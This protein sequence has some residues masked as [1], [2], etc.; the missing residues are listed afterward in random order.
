MAGAWTRSATATRLA[1]APGHWPI[2]TFTVNL[3]GALILGALLE[4]LSRQTTDRP[5]MSR[6]RLLAGTGFCG[7]LT[8]YSTLAV[9][10]DLLTRGHHLALAGAYALTSVGLGLLAT[11]TGIAA[12]STIRGRR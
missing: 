6:L 2:A 11:A 8:T 4:T 12:A 9:E 3:I 5:W 7:A 10:V 1:V